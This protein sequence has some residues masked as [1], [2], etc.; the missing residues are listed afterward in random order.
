[1]RTWGNIKGIVR[2]KIKGRTGGVVG[3]TTWV[4]SWKV[5]TSRAT[6]IIYLETYKNGARFLSRM[7]ERSFPRFEKAQRKKSRAKQWEEWEVVEEV[8]LAKKRMSEMLKIN[9]VCVCVYV[10][11][12][13]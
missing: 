11:G 8:L 1:M 13:I 4:V 5:V 6:L 12:E 7:R 3:K 2:W 10:A 9:H